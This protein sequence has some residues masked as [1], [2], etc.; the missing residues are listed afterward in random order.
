MGFSHQNSYRPFVQHTANLILNRCDRA[1]PLF[2]RPKLL[3]LHSA[4]ANTRPSFDACL[5]DPRFDPALQ[6]D[7]ILGS[8]AHP[9]P[10]CLLE[11]AWLSWLSLS[12]H[13]VHALG[14]EVAILLWGLRFLGEAA[15]RLLPHN[16]S[17]VASRLNVADGVVRSRLTC[18]RLGALGT[19]RLLCATLG[20]RL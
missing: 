16:L 8:S 19:L 15:A 17:I 9:A 10:T 12:C 20:L 18:G 4:L 3:P 13:H 6:G 1:E 2:L 14:A 7:P 5:A 11:L